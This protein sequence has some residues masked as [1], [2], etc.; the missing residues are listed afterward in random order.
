MKEK[1]NLL[2]KG[3]FDYGYPDLRVS[4]KR[5]DLEIEAGSR[6][7]GEFEVYSTNGV[8]IRAKVFSSNKQMCCEETDIIGREHGIWRK[9][10]RTY[11]YYQ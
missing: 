10:R 7:S 5:L 4:V 2:S 1:I 3:I 8:E 6:F 9:S 11:Q